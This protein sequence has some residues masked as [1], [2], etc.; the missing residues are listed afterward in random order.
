[1]QKNI[2]NSRYS[3]ALYKFKYYTLAEG[4][5]THQSNSECHSSLQSIYKPWR[6]VVFAWEY[7]LLHGIVL[8]CDLF[9]FV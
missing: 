1:M 7:K 9:V 8:D 2:S 5:Y 4:I 6:F 3:T